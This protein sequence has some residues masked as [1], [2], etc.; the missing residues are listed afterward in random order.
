[1]HH[2]ESAQCDLR[3]A[4]PGKINL[5]LR[6]TR[7]RPDGTSHAVPPQSSTHPQI[8][9]TVSNSPSIL[10]HCRTCPGFHELASLFQSISLHDTLHF[11]LKTGTDPDAIIDTLE[12]DTPGVPTDSSNLVLKALAKFRERTGTSVYFHVRLDKRIPHEAGLGGGSSNAATALWAANE[13]TGRPATPAMLAEFGAEF[14][15]DISFFLSSGTAYCTGRGEIIEDIPYLGDRNLYIVKPAEGLSTGLVFKNFDIDSC[16]TDDPRELL[17]SIQRDMDT[18]HFVNDLE[19]PSFMI[20]PRLQHLKE[21]LHRE[22]FKVGSMRRPWFTI[23]YVQ[24]APQSL[25]PFML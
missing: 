21:S 18:A 1:M 22:G 14:G 9:H 7:K 13:L 25:S 11:T 8:V 23:S 20:M 4:S 2:P 12:C 17:S 24:H 10:R 6:I 5:F 19:R 3:L 15:S 16:S